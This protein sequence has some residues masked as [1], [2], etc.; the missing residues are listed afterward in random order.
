MNNFRMKIKK[1]SVVALT[2]MIGLFSTT[3]LAFDKMTPE[4]VIE[5]HVASIGTAEARAAV[6]SIS[7]IGTAKATFFGRGGGVAEGISVAASKGGK[8]MVAMKFNNPDYP[9]E[10]MGFNESNFTVGFLSPGKRTTLGDFLQVNRS[11]F[12]RG[13]MSGALSTS[14][15]LLNPDSNDAKI[16]YSGMG[17]IDGK[18]YHEL[19]YNPR[20]GSDLSIKLF[21]D[22]ETFRHVRTE[23]KR[24]ISSRQGGNVD[25]SSSLSE[26]RY[27]M[28]EDYS[29]FSEESKLTLPHTY[30]ISLEILTGNGTTSYEWLMNFSKFSINAEIDDNDFNV[31]SY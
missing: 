23:Y 6:K 1:V 30:K 22:P 2:L 24:T 14:W 11:A 16:R 26:T 25:A 28:V 7:M 19:E 18:K 21:F 3:L 15:E 4:E 9:F 8:F 29:D 27:K 20:K 13:I 5:K 12:E 10:K 31:D 17:K